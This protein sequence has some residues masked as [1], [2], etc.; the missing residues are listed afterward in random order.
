MNFFIT[1]PIFA[2]AIALMM[3]LAGV[4]AMLMLPISQYPDLVPGQV[5]VSTQ[6]IGAS[7]DVVA[8]TV[9]TPLEEQL[10]GAEGMIYM[11]SNSTN[12][13]DSII[14]MTFDVG[15]NQNFAQME[16]LTRSN[17]ALSQLPPEVNQ[18]GLTITKQSTNLV[19]S[20]NLKSPN[21]TLDGDF[22]QNYADIHLTDPLSRIEGVASINNFALRKYAMRIWLDT[23]RLAN[24][25]M[26]AMDVEDALREQNN[27]VAAGKLGQPPVP[28]GQS[29]IFQLN[30]LGRLETPEQFED[31]IIRANS[32]G[33]VVRLKDVARV[34][35]GGEDYTWSVDS[36]G[37]PT[38]IL[39]IY[40][41][42]NANSITISNE[43]KATMDEL[44]KHFPD[45]LEWAVAYESAAYIKES[46]KEVVITLVEAILLVIL[47]VYIFLQNFR[48]TL[49][50]T[51]AIPVSLI[52]TFVF[53]QAF[54]FSINT[55]TLLGLVVAV[56]LV[57]DDAIVVVENV[58]RHL[59]AAGDADV[60]MQEI[61]EK[62]MAEV[63]G[64]IIATSLV[65]MAV[66][67]P[68]AFIPGMTGM[69]YNQ[70]ALTIAIAVGL[71]T[72]NSLTLSPALA[73]ILLRPE[74]GEKN[75]FARG[76]NNAFDKLSSGSARLVEVLSKAWLLVLL[77]FIGLCFLT[78]M[79]FKLVPAAFVPD[80]DQGYFVIITKLP[81]GASLQR[82]QAV[83]DQVSK[84]AMNTPGVN[85]VQSIPGYNFVDSI[86]DTSSVGSLIMLKSFDERQTP[87]THAFAI[88]KSIQAEVSKIPDAMIV[89][90]NAP[91]IPGLGAT[92][93]F[94]FEIQ[95]LNSQGPKELA[96]VAKIIVTEANKRP[97]LAGVYTTFDPEVPQRFL[98]IDREK[99][100]TRGVSLS[101]VFS[102]LQINLGSLYVNQFNQFGRIYRVYLQAEQD[103]RLHEDDISRLHVRNNTGEMIPL[104]AFV[105]IKSIVGPYNSPHYNQY[106][107]VQ[108]NGGAAPGYS[109]GQANAAMEQ[110]A[111]EHLPEG[112]G[113]EWTNMVYQQKKAGNMAPIVF[114]MSLIFVFLVLAAQYESWSMPL[115]ILLAIPLGLLG[116]IAALALRDMSLDV[117]GQIGLVMLIGLVAKNS[118]FIVEFAK[119]QHDA[120]MGILES[121]TEALRIRLRP[122]LMTAVAFIVGL[123]P[124]VV[125]SGAGANS[126]QSLGTAI[127]G[128]LALATVLIVFVPIF[129]V[130][131]K[132]F[133]ERKSA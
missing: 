116:A 95:D 61:T 10:N 44:S 108:V 129:F 110:V 78:V 22:M 82:S 40:Q 60:D 34:E 85:I 125:A 35:L 77:A 112:Y 42:A 27:Q 67:V 98:D 106:A 31:I 59:D 102:T 53:M 76:F 3:I 54:G 81:S 29:F 18:V 75:R 24:M 37:E 46:T 80:E 50:P 58:N 71:S 72:F 33:T 2:A 73:A 17:Q 21:G 88:I 28:A 103:A 91:S 105:T 117:Y 132:R 79:L 63:R 7:S 119:E 32:D 30:V 14:T 122:I 11:S 131:I 113:H 99:V 49:I 43:I 19:L 16:A 39:A 51:I 68:V 97:E 25:G 57:V 1:R 65:L 13:G 70:F 120:G 62:A 55:L 104:S 124:L 23:E 6:Y 9:T 15:Y 126:R 64:P 123:F 8:K 114:A 115:M 107:S 86:Q 128:G 48:S 89:V 109:S 45:D 5:Q 100:K 66:F 69:L 101:D 121:A 118:I 74:R 4:I 38:A 26:T 47:V 93:G 41:L 90:A 94:N 56:A 36:N 52:G 83:A 87:E 20:M 133:T 84:I 96:K 111:K 130:V 12:N 92:G 127:V